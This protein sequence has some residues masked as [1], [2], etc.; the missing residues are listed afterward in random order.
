MFKATTVSDEA[1][2]T[3]KTTNEAMAKLTKNEGPVEIVYK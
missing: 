2:K 3:T 1:N